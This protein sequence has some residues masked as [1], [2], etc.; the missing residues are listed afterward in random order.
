MVAAFETDAGL[1]VQTEPGP[2]TPTTLHFRRNGTQEWVK[3]QIQTFRR[4]KVSIPSPSAEQIDAICSYGRI[5]L[6]SRDLGQTWY[7][8]QPALSS[9]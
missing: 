7:S 8:A 2:G 9:N 3:N 5:H 6:V 1:F 4:C